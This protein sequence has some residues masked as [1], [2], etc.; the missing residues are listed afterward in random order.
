MID[1]SKKKFVFCSPVTPIYDIHRYRPYFEFPIAAYHFGFEPYL[2]IGRRNLEYHGPVKI[3]ETGCDSDR[4]IDVLRTLPFLLKFITRERPNVFVFF[5][6]NLVLPIIVGVT[7]MFGWGRKMKFVLKMDWDGRTFKQL[8]KFMIIRNFLLAIESFF[9]D[10]IIIENTCGYNSLSSIPLINRNKII[11]LPN[12]YSNDFIQS[13]DYSA[14]ERKP[15]VLTVSRISTEKG[16]DILISAFGTLSSEFPEWKLKIVGPVEDAAY[17]QKC[18]SLIESLNMQSR[19]VFTGPHYGDSLEW[20]YHYSSIFCLT[21]LEESFGIVR[22]EAIAAGL[23][24]I[25]S[26]A[27][28]G[29]D[30]ESFGSLVFKT[31]NITELTEHLRKLMK[32]EKTRMEISKKQQSSIISY[33][34]IIENLLRSLDLIH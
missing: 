6:M 2:L 14:F 10:S 32:D 19:I 29:R 24:L 9:V 34:E 28:C 20:D 1:G 13:A 23:P 33:D 25:T 17:Y 7:R 31:G 11:L 18:Q 30:F 26:E 21:S 5:H 15:V 12:G 16:L 22:V 27:G 8:G 3:F 4:H